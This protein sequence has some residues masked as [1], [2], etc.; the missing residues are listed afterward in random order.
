[1]GVSK[2][3]SRTTRNL[4]HNSGVQ[5]FCWSLGHFGL[6]YGTICPYDS[7][8]LIEVKKD[9]V[10]QKCRRSVLPKTDLHLLSENVDWE[11]GPGG[12]PSAFLN[13]LTMWTVENHDHLPWLHGFCC[14]AGTVLAPSLSLQPHSQTA[15]TMS[16]KE[17]KHRAE[18]CVSLRRASSFTLK[19][20]HWVKLVLM[21]H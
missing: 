13:S 4:L 17:E 20:W 18:W 3:T 15:E 7:L 12:P 21:W 5:V 16:S 11:S 14:Q 2:P 8:F 6:W 10:L 19:C 9:E 1:M